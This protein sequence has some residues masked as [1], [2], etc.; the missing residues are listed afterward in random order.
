MRNVALGDVSVLRAVLTFFKMISPKIRKESSAKQSMS[1][2]EQRLQQ[3][4]FDEAVCCVTNT[5]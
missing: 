1:P 3:K 2:K 5:E 4:Q